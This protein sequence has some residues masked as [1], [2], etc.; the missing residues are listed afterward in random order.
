MAKGVKETKAKIP[1]S[2]ALKVM[3]S[4]PPFDEAG[5]RIKITYFS[6]HQS[7]ALI[8]RLLSDLL[9]PLHFLSTIGSK[10]IIW[11]NKVFQANK[12]DAQWTL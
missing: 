5:D 3:F 7:N 9:L 12:V 2:I 4:L 10:K 6:F 11:R 1:K 8:L